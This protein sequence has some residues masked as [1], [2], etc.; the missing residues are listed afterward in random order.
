M[1]R[2][3]RKLTIGGGIVSVDID[4]TLEDIVKQALQRTNPGVLEEMEAV[5]DKIFD[6]A[7]RRWP[8]DSGKSKQGLEKS[9]RIVNFNTLEV[10]ITNKVKY[11]FFI[12][13]KAQ[14]RRRTWNVLVSTPGSRA[15]TRLA[16][17]IG[18]RLAETLVE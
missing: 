14:N 15:G 13:G 7:I 11:T 2:R 1:A 17:K 8:V 16:E 9:R 10:F 4:R 6:R 3:R 18:D 12:R 5:S